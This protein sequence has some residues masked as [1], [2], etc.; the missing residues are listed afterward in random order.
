[1]TNQPRPEIK[2]LF[3][4]LLSL[5]PKPAPCSPEIRAW[6][7]DTG[8]PTIKAQALS[9]LCRNDEFPP[10]LLGLMK[11]GTMGIVDISKATHGTWG[12]RAS[13]DATAKVHQ[14]AAMIPG[15][16]ASVFCVE[17]WVLKSKGPER[18]LNR[19]M[20][21]YPN[22]GDHPDREEAV[23]FNMLHYDADTNTMMQLTTHVMVIKVLG[24]NRSRRAWADTKWGA[25]ETTD[26][27]SP[28]ATMRMVGRFIFGSH[29]DD[30]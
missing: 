24:T 16:M 30:K 27:H 5:N 13:K 28:D 1:M 6:W 11:G 22:L 17:T 23:M 14:V 2:E 26:P 15:T 12:N 19:Q 3:D 4:V 20:D 7:L 29:A 9:E 8:L 10:R 25:E 21:K 18:E